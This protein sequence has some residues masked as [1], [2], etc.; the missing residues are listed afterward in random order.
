MRKENG[1][2]PDNDKETFHIPHNYLSGS[3]CSAPY[4]IF[5][6]SCF[7]SFCLFSSLPLFV[8]SL[9]RNNELV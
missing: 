8:T 7:S 4:A 2:F 5:F 3:F 6:S 9:K 1:R